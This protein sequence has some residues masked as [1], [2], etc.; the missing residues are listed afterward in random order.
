MF[1]NVSRHMQTMLGQK[2][3]LL[4]HM[5]LSEIN[6]RWMKIQK[7]LPW[8]QQ[9]QVLLQKLLTILNQK[10]QELMIF[11]VFRYLNYLICY[12]YKFLST[13]N[14]IGRSDIPL[15]LKFLYLS[16]YNLF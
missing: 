16:T 14:I 10:E 1:L 2:F 7:M 9:N 5:F 3:K 8:K 6:V 11:K 15:V 13:F 12:V 4:H